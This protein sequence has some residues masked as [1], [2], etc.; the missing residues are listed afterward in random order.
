[1]AVGIPN[2]TNFNQQ[3][4]DQQAFL[5]SQMRTQCPQTA[6][7]SD[8]VTAKPVTSVPHGLDGMVS[9]DMQQAQNSQALTKLLIGACNSER[10]QGGYPPFM[11]R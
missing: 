2:I 9:A 8:R 5:I 10:A 1:M 4:A 6:A 3:A 11:S 7:L